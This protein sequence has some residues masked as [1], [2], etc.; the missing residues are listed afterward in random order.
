M[1]YSRTPP[2][3]TNVV[4]HVLEM[5]KWVASEVSHSFELPPHAHLRPDQIDEYKRQVRRTRGGS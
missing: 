4:T 5:M 1:P 2:A 3:I